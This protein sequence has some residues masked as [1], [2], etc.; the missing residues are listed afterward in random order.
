ME[1]YENNQPVIKDGLI[2]IHNGIIV[3][4]RRLW[5]NFPDLERKFEVDTEIILSLVRKFYEESGALVETFRKTFGLLE[6]TASVGLLFNDLNVLALATNNGSL[7]TCSDESQGLFLFAS[8]RFILQEVIKHSVLLQR[9]NR[10]P[11]EQVK[12]GNGVLI[13]I[14]QVKAYPFSLDLSQPAESYT[15]PFVQRRLVTLPPSHNHAEHI[16]AP[17]IIP[18]GRLKRFEIDMGVALSLRRCTRCLLPDTMPFIEFDEHGV[19]NYCHNYQKN[20]ILGEDTLFEALEQYRRKNNSLSCIVALSGGRDS[21]Y[22]LHYVKKVLNLNPIAY[23]YDWGMVTDLARRNQARLCGKLGVEHILVSANL[24]HKRANIRKN[25]LAWLKRPDLGTVPL[26]MA[27]DK[28]YFFYANLVKRHTNTPI[29]IFGNNPLE[30]TNFK[31]GFC[32]IRPS[33]A[34]V[35]AYA[36]TSFNKIKIAAYYAKEFLLNPAYLNSSISDTLGAFASYYVVPHNYLDIYHY[37][38][39]DEKK[40][41]STIINEYDWE[42]ATDTQSTW[43][44]GDGTAPFYNYIYCTVAGFTENDTFRSNQIREGVLTRQEAFEIVADENQARFDSIQWYCN[45]IGIDMETTLERIQSIPKRYNPDGSRK[46]IR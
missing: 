10:S 43:R 35:Q 46:S 1:I 33:F 13:D 39:W 4:D 3:N 18:K 36:L 27:G 30:A 23:T 21:C 22:S 19:C 9:L 24:S 29:N 17:T 32:G 37:I 44:I 11:I 25:V 40:I 45:T 34:N 41:T 14:A 12:P 5:M 15:A 31:T 26:F 8:E 7:Y 38:P 28:Q 20:E 2:G 6:G 42:L 16:P